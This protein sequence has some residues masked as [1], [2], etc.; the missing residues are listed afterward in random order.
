MKRQMK[1]LISFGDTGYLFFRKFSAVMT[2]VMNIL[3]TEFFVKK[4]LHFVLNV[5]V[6]WFIMVTIFMAKKS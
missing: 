1:E 5:T 3:Q 4:L 2:T 6:P